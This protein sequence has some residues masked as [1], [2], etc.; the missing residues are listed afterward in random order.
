MVI[1][2]IIG[3][4]KRVHAIVCHEDVPLSA[5]PPLIQALRND[6]NRGLNVGGGEFNNVL[7]DKAAQEI[8]AMLRPQFNIGGEHP[9]GQKVGLLDN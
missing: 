2:N 9:A 5:Y 1:E 8:A 4:Q 7:G 6:L 3:L